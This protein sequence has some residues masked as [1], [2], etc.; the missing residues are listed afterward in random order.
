MYN[1]KYSYIQTHAAHGVIS[2]HIKWKRGVDSQSFR[3]LF[4]LIL[5]WTTPFT[6][7]MPSH[8]SFSSHKAFH[9]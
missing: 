4:G 1:K 2:F 3:I 8:S 6:T 9:M 7:P 5:K